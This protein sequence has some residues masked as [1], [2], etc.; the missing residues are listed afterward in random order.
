MSLPVK[1]DTLGPMLNALLRV[2]VF[3]VQPAG[4]SGEMEYGPVDPLQYQR[5]VLYPGRHEQ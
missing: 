4:Y 2:L 1:N 3:N 5:A